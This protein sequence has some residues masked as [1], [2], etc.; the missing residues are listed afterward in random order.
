MTKLINKDKLDVF[1]NKLWKRIT[2]SFVSKTLHN[3]VTGETMI[4]DGYVGGESTITRMHNE[5]RA[6]MDFLNHNTSFYGIPSL[7]VPARTYVDKIICIMGFRLTIRN[8]NYL[9]CPHPADFSIVL[10]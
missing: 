9:S 1:T 10:D 2:K 7:S 4:T 8:V 6:T 3:T 5:T